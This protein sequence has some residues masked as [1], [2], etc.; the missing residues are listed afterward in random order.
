M[1]IISHI[2]TS[3]SFL[4]HRSAPETC[5][6]LENIKKKNKDKDR[7]IQKIIIIIVLI[8]TTRN[9]SIIS[10]WWAHKSSP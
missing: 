3:L 6:A 10:T 8:I 1:I 5:D 4:F 9:S 7:D 2:Y